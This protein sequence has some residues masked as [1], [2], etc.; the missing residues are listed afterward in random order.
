MRNIFLILFSFSLFTF[1]AF[2]QGHNEADGKA[3]GETE[4][5]ADDGHSDAENSEEDFNMVDITLHHISDA[6]EFHIFGDIHMPLPCILFAK[7]QGWTFCMS[8]KFHHGEHAYNGYVLDHGRVKRVKPG[9]G[10]PMEGVVEIGHHAIHHK[11]VE[12]AE[13]KTKEVGYFEY[14]GKTFELEHASTLD[15][16]F[17]GGAFTSYYDL[18]ITRNVFTMI[19]AALLLIFFVYCSCQGLPQ[20]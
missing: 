4:S 1:S 19:L 15:G 17:L 9:Q 6:N 12:V 11:D 5:H 14:Q 7:D 18:S 2:A 20:E 8:S 16:G 10:F 13:G 3:H